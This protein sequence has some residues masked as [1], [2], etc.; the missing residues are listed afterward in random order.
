MRDR[1]VIRTHAFRRFG[2]DT[3]CIFRDPQQLS[4]VGAKRSSVRTDLGRGQDQRRVEVHDC[5]AGL[6]YPPERF[7]QKD[8]RVSPLPSRVGRREERPDIRRSDCSQQG[9]GD[10][11]E[12]DVAVG[13]AA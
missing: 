12:E 10:G 5:I 7:L 4:N 13:M 11:V 2:F 9:I 8:R 1:G 6:V 3:N